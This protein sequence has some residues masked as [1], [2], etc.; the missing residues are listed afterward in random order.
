M[1]KYR[2]HYAGKAQAH[3]ELE[4]KDGNEAVRLVRARKLRVD[5]EIWGHEGFVARVPPYQP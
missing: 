1:P 4:A 3:D 2:L 5:C